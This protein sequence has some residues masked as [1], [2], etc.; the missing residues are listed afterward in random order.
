MK[1]SYIKPMAPKFTN[2]IMEA[3]AA[4]HLRMLFQTYLYLRHQFDNL[5]V[6]LFPLIA[7]IALKTGNS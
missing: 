1:V 7:K 5:Q 4:L 6:L 2:P 3:K